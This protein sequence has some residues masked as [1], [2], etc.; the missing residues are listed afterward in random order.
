MLLCNVLRARQYNIRV[1][2]F[3]ILY[4]EKLLA[5]ILITSIQSRLFELIIK[6][7]IKLNL[8]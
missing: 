2:L 6:T 3:N 5:K 4:R 1:I 8:V 7:I